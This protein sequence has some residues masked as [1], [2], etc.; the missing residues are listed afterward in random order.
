M[1]AIRIEVRGSFLE[2]DS[3]RE[4][5][6]IFEAEDHGHADAVAQAVEFLAGRLLPAATALDHRLHS[7]GSKPKLG[8]ERQ[9]T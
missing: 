6:R 1:G 4:F 7:K 8:W 5:D 2:S 3:K 9:R